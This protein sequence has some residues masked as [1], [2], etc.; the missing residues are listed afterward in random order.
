MF[1]TKND[2]YVSY[3]KEYM[4]KINDRAKKTQ[5]EQDEE[6]LDKMDIKNIENYLRKKKL[7]KI[8]K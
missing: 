2:M 5:I 6:T 1:N 3:I 8:K 4:E 7:E